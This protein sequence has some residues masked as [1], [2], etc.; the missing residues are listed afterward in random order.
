MLFFPHAYLLFWKVENYD[1]ARKRHVCHSVL[2][3]R[4]LKKLEHTLVLWQRVWSATLKHGV[5]R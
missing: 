3:F 1:A 2:K 5:D 4:F